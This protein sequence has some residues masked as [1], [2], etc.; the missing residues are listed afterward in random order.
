MPNDER[1]KKFGVRNW[2]WG[3]RGEKREKKSLMECGA[4]KLPL[5]ALSGFLT[6][7]P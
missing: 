3:D 5:S 1:L 6:R 2:E 7:D 4:D